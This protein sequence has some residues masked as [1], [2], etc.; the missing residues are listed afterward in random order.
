MP[1]SACV[2]C[3]FVITGV[4]PWTPGCSPVDGA[5]SVAVDA[6]R[7]GEMLSP[8]PVERLAGRRRG[9]QRTAD[10]WTSLMAQAAAMEGGSG[11]RLLGF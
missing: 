6:G 2:S 9:W 4:A 7:S 3:T 8:G 5:T 11:T 10:R 1:R